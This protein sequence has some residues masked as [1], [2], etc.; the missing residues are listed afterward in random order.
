MECKNCGHGLNDTG[1]RHFSQKFSF[2]SSRGCLEIS[3]GRDCSCVKP[4]S[5]FWENSKHTR[6]FAACNRCTGEQAARKKS[7]RTWQNGFIT[8]CEA[9]LEELKVSP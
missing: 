7:G 9:H 6:G 4:E 8:L 2:S 3:N 1:T 5:R